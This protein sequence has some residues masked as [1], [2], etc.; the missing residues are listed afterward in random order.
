MGRKNDLDKIYTKVEIAEWL[1]SLCQIDNFKTIIEPSAGNG[2]FSNI[3]KCLAFDIEPEDEKI[4]KADFLMLDF[5][6]VEKPVLVIGNPPF[7]R[8]N[9]LAIQFIK[10]ASTFADCIAFILPKSFKKQ[11]IKNRIPLNFHL[12]FEID[13]PDNSFTLLRKEI[14]IPCIFQIWDKKDTLREKEK[15]LHP[16]FFAF[17]NKNLANMSFRRV[18]IYAGKAS[19]DLNKSKQSHYF[20]YT[21]NPNELV[22]KINSIKWNQENTVGPRSISKQ[23]LIKAL[24]QEK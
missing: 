3:I 22:E 14:N 18:G 24:E 8:Q 19:L 5:S 17:V 15:R 20:I 10:K 11:S 21:K 4:E 12:K 2:S 16:K 9:N 6:K 7:G 13:I 23:E 1:I